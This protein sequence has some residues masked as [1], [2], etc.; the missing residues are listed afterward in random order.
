MNNKFYIDEMV[1]LYFE[2]GSLTKARKKIKEMM[3]EDKKLEKV[4][5]K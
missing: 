4:A 5:N 2:L 1:R 3:K